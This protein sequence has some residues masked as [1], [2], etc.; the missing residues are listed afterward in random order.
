DGVDKVAFTGSTEVGKLIVK[1]AAGLRMRALALGGS[2][3]SSGGFP[4]PKKPEAPEKDSSSFDGFG[5]HDA[6]ENSGRRSNT[7]SSRFP[8]VISG[9]QCE[10]S[11]VEP[12]VYQAGGFRN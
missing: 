11:S 12:Q 8:T 7:E 1:A 10:I 2:L 5:N 4:P 3:S 9:L 6:V